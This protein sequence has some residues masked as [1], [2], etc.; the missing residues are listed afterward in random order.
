[1]TK[2]SIKENGKFSFKNLWI[3]E[4]RLKAW[5]KAFEEPVEEGTLQSAFLALE[6]AGAVVHIGI[7]KPDN[8]E[9]KEV[10]GEKVVIFKKDKN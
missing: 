4:E 2:I 5:I 6:K 8:V 7:Q 10:N 9:I 3:W 1:M